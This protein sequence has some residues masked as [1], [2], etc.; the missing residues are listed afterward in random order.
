MTLVPFEASISGKAF[1]NTYSGEVTEPA[2]VLDMDMIDSVEAAAQ[3]ARLTAPGFT[4]D[5][6]N[7]QILTTEELLDKA[8]HTYGQLDL[9]LKHQRETRFAQRR[10]LNLSKFDRVWD[11]DSWDRLDIALQATRSGDWSQLEQYGIYINPAWFGGIAQSMLRSRPVDMQVAAGRPLVAPESDDHRLALD[12][13]FD[14]QQAGLEFSALLRRIQGFDTVRPVVLVDDLLTSQLFPIDAINRWRMLHAAQSHLLHAQTI[15]QADQ[16]GKD[17]RLISLADSAD[18]FERLQALLT[19]SPAGLVVNYKD[20]R[21]YLRP[22][23]RIYKSVEHQHCLSNPKLYQEGVQLRKQDGSPTDIAVRAGS[24]LDSP[25]N[26]TH[27][28]LLSTSIPRRTGVLQESLES[29]QELSL[30]LQ[31]LD[32]AY[33]DS[34][35][36]IYY[37]S[38]RVTAD[39]VVHALTSLLYNEIGTIIQM[40]QKLDDVR[41][42]MK[43]RDY[44]LHNY[45]TEDVW[46]EDIQGVHVIANELP[47]HYDPGEVS[48]AAVIGYGPFSYPA[49]G[50]APFM[51][52]GA[53][54]HISDLLEANIDF[55]KDWFNGN[56]DPEHARVYTNF[57]ELFTLSPQSGDLF[58][59]CEAQLRNAAELQVIALEDLPTDFAQLVVESFVSC[60][61]N[62]EK[63]GFYNS[64]KQKARILQ[65]GNKSM[66][67]SV[68]M[69][70]SG[71]W[72][73]SGDQE[74]ITIP[75]TRLTLEEIEDG[76][77]SAGLRIV[78]RTA[79]HADASFR[80]DHKGMVVIF[81]KPD[82][83]RRPHSIPLFIQ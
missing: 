11:K 7:H 6:A 8:H 12:T 61:R 51:R 67:I 42:A 3:I 16:P 10:S 79:L 52:P 22:Y 41:T 65:W 57:A 62:I 23:E 29:S 81:A 82:T 39:H 74:G 31:A 35:Q 49:L 1:A 26:V 48:S 13:L 19:E 17:F 59:D 32:L 83:R 50:I 55:A 37:D 71:G 75:A 21:S 43:P 34:D 77:R 72:S 53:K 80:E 14:K 36:N 78:K 70:G 69:V 73:N 20:G 33:P 76:Y 27:L 66:M 9:E 38:K 40:L 28:R 58:N 25:T 63:L 68:H 60:S 45:N 5:K 56:A 54:I 30:I 15:T 44:F 2:S 24:Y 18:Q 64:I 47:L 46:P 4:D